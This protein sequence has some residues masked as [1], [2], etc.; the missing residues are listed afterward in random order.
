MPY[1]RNIPQSPTYGTNATTTWDIRS[2][3]AV[4]R[5]LCIAILASAARLHD[6]Y[7]RIR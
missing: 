2:L 7:I 6:V 5:I 4:L 1:T 3:E